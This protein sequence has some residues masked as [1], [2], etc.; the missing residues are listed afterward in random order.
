MGQG[1]VGHEPGESK[2]PSTKQNELL[3]L[4]AT[5]ADPFTGQDLEGC[6]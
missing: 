1:T 2:S 4:L 5:R 3:R 6:A